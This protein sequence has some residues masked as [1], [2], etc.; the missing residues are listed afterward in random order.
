MTASSPMRR[1]WRPDLRI[2]LL[3]IALYTLASAS[4]AEIDFRKFDNDWID[5][6]YRKALELHRDN[7]DMLVGQGLLAD[8]R[9][10]YIDLLAI[11]TGAGPDT[12]VDSFLATAGS[13]AQRSLAVIAASP[14]ELRNALKFIGM[15]EGHPIDLSRTLYWPKGERVTM[16]FYW[17]DTGAPRFTRSV[18]AEQLLIDRRWD[19][20]L[21]MLGM[22][23]VGPADESTLLAGNGLV[24]TAFNAQNTILEIPYLANEDEQAGEL[25]ANAEYPFAAGQRLRIRI[26]PEFAE[27]QKRVLDLVVDVA[28]GR[29][30]NPMQ[31]QNMHVTLSSPDGSELLSGNFESMFVYLKALTDDGKEPYLQLRYADQ[32]S[33]QAV[34]NTARFAQQF[35]TQQEI[36]IEPNQS[37]LFY[38][39]LLPQES[40]RDPMLR[41]RGTQP[42][43]IYWGDAAT[44][45]EISG[46]I[47]QYQQSAADVASRQSFTDLEELEAALQHGSPWQTDGIF[48]M[49]HPTTRY[50]AVR[51][52]FELIKNDFPHIYVF[53]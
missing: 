8:A 12:S 15:T 27:G 24:A 1:L 30:A 17:S 40:W 37:H 45:D 46:Q 49:V 19:E 22:R 11:A 20:Q 10:R 36:R 25:L 44:A 31:L 52:V 28:P 33:M 53:L 41:G 29:D 16:T 3:G 42:L 35:L 50:G 23:F 6:Q 51:Q 39:A 32:V 7:P 4:A 13:D 9:H 21:P 47:V 43:E 5:G 34:R 14:A 2:A 38:S 18:R 48:L 26:R